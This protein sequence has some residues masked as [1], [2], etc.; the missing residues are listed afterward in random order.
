M[1]FEYTWKYVT[2]GQKSRHPA[3]RGVYCDCFQRR[4]YVF[5]HL[6]ICKTNTAAVRKGL[7]YG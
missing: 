1:L 7:C 2:S 3:G 4:Y 6:G 5:E